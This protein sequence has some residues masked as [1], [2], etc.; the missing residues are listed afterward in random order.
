MQASAPRRHPWALGM[1]GVGSLRGPQPLCV[2]LQWNFP[3]LMLVWK[4]LLLS[5]AGTP[6]LGMPAEQTPLTALYLGSLIKEVRRP[7]R[8]CSMLSGTFPLPTGR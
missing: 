8:K 4:R 1:G 3:L 5:A 6:C 7:R 2:L